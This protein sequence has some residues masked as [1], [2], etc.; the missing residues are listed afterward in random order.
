MKMLNSPQLSIFETTT[1]VNTPSPVKTPVQS[2]TINIFDPLKN[3]FEEIFPQNL[4]ENKVLKMRRSLSERAKNMSDEEIQCV[5]A[6]FQFLIDSW[7]DEFEK[8]VFDGMTL[9]EVLNK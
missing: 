1:T 5:T 8:E 3:A 9:K 7:L 6:K 2:K 4:E